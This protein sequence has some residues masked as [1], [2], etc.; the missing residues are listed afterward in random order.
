MPTSPTLIWRRQVALSLFVQGGGAASILLIT[1][2]LGVTTGPEAQGNFSHTKAAIEFVAAFAM[3][4]LPQ[5]LFFFVRSGRM[6]LRTALR[7]VGVNALAAIFIG[8]IFWMV[9][10]RPSSNIH[11]LA[12]AMAIASCVAH[13]QL[14]TLLLLARHPALFNVASA[15]P[16]VLLMLGVTAALWSGLIND[17]VWAL[18]FAGAFGASSIFSLWQLKR[19]ERAEVVSPANWRDIA[20]YGTAAWLLASLST[21]AILL[22]QWWVEG[23]HGAAALGRFTIA[24]TLIQVPLAPLGYVAPLLLRR[25]IEQPAQRTARRWAGALC[26]ALLSVAL[27]IWLAAQWLP[28]L[29]LGPAYM[30]TTQAL[31]VLM[32]GAAAEAAS[33]VLTVDV[34]AN[35]LPWLAVRAEVAR[36]LVLGLAFALLPSLTLLGICAVWAA[37]AFATATVFALHARRS[38]RPGVRLA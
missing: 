17:S 18:L 7:W 28:D 23:A 13:G 10:R 16:Q 33:R 36:W 35:G 15:L 34:Y 25:W 29:G 3:F 8:W 5:A 20:H 12:F 24:M 6:E 1:L 21:A 32:V 38:T 14:R 2:M 26:A 27:M 30:G 37:A 31:A 19:F 11:T 22:V 4:G 9:A